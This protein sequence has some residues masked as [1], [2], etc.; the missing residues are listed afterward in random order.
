MR[1][2]VFVL[3][4]QLV[5]RAANGD[6]SLL[7]IGPY[8]FF[9]IDL[10][11][12]LL[13]VSI[14]L[15]VFE[16]GNFR[17]VAI[18]A[19]AF[20]FLELLWLLRGLSH[21]AWDAFL[22][23]RQ[24]A[25]MPLLFVALLVRRSPGPK[26]EDYMP[27]LLLGTVAL[28][29]LLAARLI[30]GPTLFISNQGALVLLTFNEYR[31]LDSFSAMYLGC[32]SML[33]AYIALVHGGGSQFRRFGM[34]AAVALV[35]VVITRQRSAMLGIFS[36][37]AI[38]AVFSRDLVRRLP[39]WLKFVAL[40]AGIV[41]IGVSILDDPATLLSWL[42][43]S[44]QQS[45][46]KRTTLDGRLMIWDA[47]MQEFGNRTIG[48]QLLGEFAGYKPVIIVLGGLWT[49]SLHN[50]YVQTLFDTG[51]LGLV[52]FTAT[53]GAGFLAAMRARRYPEVANG[54]GL[55]P[56]LALAWLAA[57]LVYGY[58]YGWS[59]G[60]SLFPVL[61]CVPGWKLAD[62]SP[63]RNPRDGVRA[64]VLHLPVRRSRNVLRQ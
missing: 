64:T 42:P 28:L 3:I 44:F 52:A 50:V 60:I 57:L 31:P 45:I 56:A 34:L 62:R 46:E 24:Q 21:G 47:A 29:L 20:A 23:L 39:L 9:L 35:A 58:S 33:F 48:G 26:L 25:V 22:D 8:H 59:Y 55:R 49:S 51:L 27:A 61:A 18:F 4:V 40:L 16:L 13:T 11:V 15:N 30:F 5:Q 32:M 12:L 36:G 14:L 38:L 6:T 37:F 2:A 10:A 43:D 17:P 54:V 19:F 63:H 7:S 53:I 41:V 1:A